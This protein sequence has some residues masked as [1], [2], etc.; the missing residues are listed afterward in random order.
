MHARLIIGLGCGRCG[1]GSL[2]R[3]LCKQPNVVGQH[4]MMP[5]MPSTM[6]PKQ[7]IWRALYLRQRPG[8]IQVDVA[9]WYLPHVEVLLKRFPDTRF[10]VLQRNKS[11][12]VDSMLAKWALHNINPV[13]DHDGKQYRRDLPYVPPLEAAMPTYPLDWSVK[14]AAYQFYEDYY[15]ACYRLADRFPEAVRIF[16]MSDLNLEDGVRNILT[17]AGF[18]DGEMRVEVGICANTRDQIVERLTA[19]YGAHNINL[20]EPVEAV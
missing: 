16:A 4:E 18:S 20:P 19:A 9:F 7:V 3:L 11:D 10:I 14:Q 5:V 17:F 8:K 2:S 1:T 15:T 6:P 13:Q 12:C